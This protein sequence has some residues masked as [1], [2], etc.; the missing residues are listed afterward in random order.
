MR[1]GV[2]L[3]AWGPVLGGRNW[4]SLRGQWPALTRPASPRPVRDP[5]SKKQ[6]GRPV[7]N[8]S[9]VR[10]RLPHTFAHTE[11]WISTSSLFLS[12]Y[13]SFIRKFKESLGILLSFDSE[14]AKCVF[15]RG[16]AENSGI[17][18]GFSDL[19]GRGLSTILP[20]WILMVC[21]TYACRVLQRVGIINQIETPLLCTRTIIPDPLGIIPQIFI[22]I[23][24]SFIT[25]C[26]FLITR[27]LFILIQGCWEAAIHKSLVL[28]SRFLTTA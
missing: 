19:N 7:R 11:P 23:R 10:P 20:I 14:N 27:S 12:D 16:M 6:G 22:L 17:K 26:M 5:L 15:P 24:C 9:C 28:C 8:H 2:V 25:H 18:S 4:Q 3:W 13:D 1:L 21:S